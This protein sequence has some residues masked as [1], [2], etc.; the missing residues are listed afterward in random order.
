MILQ[1][2]AVL[3]ETAPQWIATVA[4]PALVFAGTV[5]VLC[6]ARYLTA[7]NRLDLSPA[8]AASGVAA[9]ADEDFAMAYRFTVW[10]IVVMAI[11]L[12]ALGADRLL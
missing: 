6:W 11:G 9:R 10:V 3:P 4:L 5:S 2:L 12:G 8:R 1:G 7:L